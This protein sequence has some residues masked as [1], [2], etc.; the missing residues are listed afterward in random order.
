MR[1]IFLILAVTT[2]YALL[3]GWP[4]ELHPVL[5]TCLAVLVLVLGLGMWR[6]RLKP[7]ASVARSVRRPRWSDYLAVGLGI[8]GVECLLLCFLSVGPPHAESISQF[9]FDKFS[10]PRTDS[11]QS[12]PENENSSHGGTVS[13][14]WLWDSQGRRSLPLSSN[15]RPSNKPEIFFRPKDEATAGALLRNRTYLRAF[16]LEKFDNATWTP[17][18][19]S[20]RLLLPDENGSVNLEQLETR[21][22]PV[23]RGEIIQPSHPRGR[24]SSLPPKGQFGPGFPNSD[25]W[26]PGSSG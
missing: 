1:S 21:P 16:T 14:N 19:M 12:S 26:T 11:T 13:G 5:R 4:G 2:S 7:R 23:L 20:P 8:L 24:T 9:V 3:R 10:P 6:Q 18:G 15:A 25:M 22:G 17:V